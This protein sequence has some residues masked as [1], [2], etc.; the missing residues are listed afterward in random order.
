M[1]DNR[2]IVPHETQD[3]EPMLIQCW[4]TVCDVGPTLN[5]HWVNV[6]CPLGGL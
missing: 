2:A 4:V 6:F 1:S 5:Q 3:V